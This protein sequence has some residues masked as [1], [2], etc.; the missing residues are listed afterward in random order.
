MQGTHFSGLS[1]TNIT[2][3]CQEIYC[4][5]VVFRVL[6]SL[7]SLTLILMLQ[8]HYIKNT[9]KHFKYKLSRIYK[10]LLHILGDVS[11]QCNFVFICFNYEWWSR[12]IVM[13]LPGQ[14]AVGR[15]YKFW[16]MSCANP[17]T[18]LSNTLI[19]TRYTGIR[20]AWILFTCLKIY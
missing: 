8:L 15:K 11:R 16:I 3:F 14:V 4:Y 12:R 19:I 17:N 7:P 2:S 10:F 18:C 5:I 1:L 20:R 13:K 6:L 9:I